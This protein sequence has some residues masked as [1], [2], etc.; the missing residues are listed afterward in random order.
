MLDRRAGGTPTSADTT[1]RRRPLQ[2]EPVGRVVRPEE[3]RRRGPGAGK[4]PGSTEPV[5]VDL[6]LLAQPYR[7][8]AAS[9]QTFITTALEDENVKRVLIVTAWIRE[10]GMELL[11]PGLQSLRSRRG[12]A[13]LL[14]GV[15]LKGSSHQGVSLARK[16]FTDAYAIHDPSGR[17]FHPKMYLALGDRVGYALIGSN[18]LTVGGLWHNY[19]AAVTAVF[20]PRREPGLSEGVKS[21]AQRLLDDKAICKRVTQGVYGRLL[22]EDWLAD[23]ANDRRLRRED[24]LTRASRRRT[25]GASPLF[26]PSQAEKRGRPAPIRADL[27]RGRVPSG[28]RR[29]LATAPD[30]WWKQLGAGDAQHP[31]AGNPT[32]NVALT[33]IPR[34]QDRA[35]F[36]RNSFFA[37]ETWRRK[38]EG[39]RRTEMVTIDALIEI[40]PDSLGR[41]RLTVV[42]RPYRRQRGRATTVLRWGETLLEELRRRDVTGWYLLIDR[43]NVGNYRLRITP[44]EPA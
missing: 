25:G 3:S 41:Q 23:E 42:Y 17:T 6:Q 7:E 8:S 33:D 24:R 34:D 21:Y 11:V 31:L 13:R 1:I 37:A 5:D 38:D 28:K 40:G 35:T 43:A 9:G 15:D 29:R 27:S 36:F 18:N 2:S 12:T 14:F 39:G 4:S 19:E 16:W 10:S 30:S 20:D 32:G 44:Q 26:T 22:S